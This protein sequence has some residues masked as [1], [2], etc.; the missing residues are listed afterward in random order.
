MRK[1]YAFAVCAAVAAASLV[2]C[3]KE[4]S[5]PNEGNRTV[6]FTV[7]ASL[8]PQTKTYLSENAGVYS[9]KW[10]YDPSKSIADEIGVFFGDFENN[11]TDVDATF[12][13]TDVTSDVATFSGEGTVSSDAVTFTSFYPASAFTR[14]YANSCIGLK[15][16]KTQ[17]PV[18][19]SFDPDMDILMGKQ[20]DIT[21]T[22]KNVELDDE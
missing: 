8:D 20:K 5:D 9:A 4:I 3:Q 17:S 15:V 14:T 18:L 1:F 19:G 22:S 7:R 2:S 16:E 10:S 13:I 21:I 12:A 6:H 11:V